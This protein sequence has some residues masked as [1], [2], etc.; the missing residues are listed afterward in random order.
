MYGYRAAKAS[1]KSSVSSDVVSMSMRVHDQFQAKI[2]IPDMLGRTLNMQRDRL[3]WLP[4]FP[5]HI[6]DM[7]LFD[8]LLAVYMFL[9]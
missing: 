5:C 6:E 4:G 8:T 9:V 1:C 3:T 7:C 2:A